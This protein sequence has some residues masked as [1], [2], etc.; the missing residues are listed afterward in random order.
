MSIRAIT[1]AWRQLLTST[2]RFVLLALADAADE[3]G[4]CWPSVSTLAERCVVSTRTVQRALQDLIVAD[5]IHCDSRQRGDGSTTSNRYVLHL[6]GGD[7]VTGAPVVDVTGECHGGQGAPVTGFTPRTTNRT[8]IDPSPPPSTAAP[9]LAASGGDSRKLIF[10]S[11]FTAAECVEAAHRLGRFPTL[12]AQQILD[13]LNGRMEHGKIKSTALAYLGGLISRARAGTF[14]PTIERKSERRTQRISGTR[15]DTAPEGVETSRQTAPVY[16]DV[17]SN[18]L[19]QRVAEIRTRADQRR[20]PGMITNRGSESAAR[21]CLTAG[22][23]P[24]LFFDSGSPGKPI[25][26]PSSERV[27]EV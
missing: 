23:V 24:V 27:A 9:E 19:C 5:L 7:T 25:E 16:P 22:A 17:T 18:P 11:N 15:Q 20:G 4:V 10:P 26:I 13:E 1:W 12:L 2:Q 14:V 8:V 3:N 21:D 6:G